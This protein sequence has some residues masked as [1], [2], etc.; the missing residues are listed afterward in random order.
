MS[1]RTREILIGAELERVLPMLERVVK[2]K[3]FSPSQQE[4]I[5]LQLIEAETENC[6]P[7][8][9]HRVLH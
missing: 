7:P 8:P 1:Q 2:Q 3:G 5:A 4:K 6:W 9:E